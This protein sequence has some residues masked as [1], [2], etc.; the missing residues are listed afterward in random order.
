MKTSFLSLSEAISPKC[1]RPLND[2][3]TKFGSSKGTKFTGVGGPE[4]IHDITS[5]G[6]LDGLVRDT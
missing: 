2:M 6:I 1:L 3:L 5:L 4:I